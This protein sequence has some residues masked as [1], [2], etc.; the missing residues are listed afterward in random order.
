M[1]RQSSAQ[2]CGLALRELRFPLAL[3]CVI[4]LAPGR[5]HSTISAGQKSDPPSASSDQPLSE[6]QS[7]HEL[8]EHLRLLT[9]EKEKLER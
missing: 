8:R 9:G 4:F 6:A 2:A 5:S 7:A 3:A 1:Q